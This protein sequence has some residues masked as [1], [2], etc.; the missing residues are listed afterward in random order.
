[1]K[2]IAQI[3]LLCLTITT[4]SLAKDACQLLKEASILYCNDQLEEAIRSLDR[5]ITIYPDHDLCEEAFLKIGDIY[6]ELEE[7]N[8]AKTIYL[9]VLENTKNDS[10]YNIISDKC[11]TNFD[12][13][14]PEKE[15]GCQRIIFPN[16]GLNIKHQAAVNLSQIFINK[17]DLP[18]AIYYLDNATNVNVYISSCGT[19]ISENNN[20][21]A[22]LY[23]DVYLKNKTP[24]L[25]LK[26]L[27]KQVF[28]APNQEI[29]RKTKSILFSEFSKEK[30][31]YEY[32]KAVG[33]IQYIKEDKI[34]KTS[35][36]YL[37]YFL[38]IKIEVYNFIFND[39]DEFSTK[40]Y[41]KNTLE[42]IIT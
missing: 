23:T 42:S 29:F 41:I 4:Q 15:F 17:L 16:Q 6:Y 22:L 37:F 18:K 27:L 39:N 13:A 24:K 38:D 28:N 3:L 11:P 8:E 1:M 21:I 26:H 36:K 32:L 33:N 14:F 9:S 7:Y 10:L 12:S 35:E 30:L 20:K 19:G 2:Q 5:F 31:Q 40:T 34:K 25:A